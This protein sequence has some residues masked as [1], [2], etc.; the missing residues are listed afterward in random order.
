[1][2]LATF[3]NNFRQI[4]VD[5]TACG[6]AG[7]EGGGRFAASFPNLVEFK[8]AFDHFGYRTIFTTS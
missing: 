5:A 4:D 2:N 8:R 1:M 3:A 6:Q 7:V